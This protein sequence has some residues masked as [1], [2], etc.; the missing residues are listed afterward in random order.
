MFRCMQASRGGAKHSGGERP[1]TARLWLLH[2]RVLASRAAVLRHG[3]KLCVPAS[4]TAANLSYYWSVFCTPARSLLY[5]RAHGVHPSL[6]DY[7]MASQ[8]FI[9]V[10][11]DVPCRCLVFQRSMLDIGSLRPG[12]Q[13]ALLWRCFK[14]AC[15]I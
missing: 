10:I 6:P 14:E 8:T 11:R 5:W 1:P 2:D 13:S 3:G 9:W 4:G 7:S 12:L 15:S